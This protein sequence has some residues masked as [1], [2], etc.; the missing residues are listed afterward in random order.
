MGIG[1]PL[2]RRAVFFDRDG[3]LNKAVVRDGRPFPPASADEVEITAGAEDATRALKDAGFLLIVV[4]NQPDVARGTTS[5]ESVEAINARLAAVL[6]IDRFVMCYHQDS[7]NCD[8]RKPKPGMLLSSA[9]ELDID[10]ASSFLVGDRWRDIEAGKAA[11]CATIFIDY[12]YD[13]RRPERPGHKASSLAEAVDIILAEPR[14]Q[15]PLTP[16]K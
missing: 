8:C 3:V 6:P 5:R 14:N 9:R 13:E 7:D 1:R 11:G 10:L 12:S 2:S 15:Q 4:S 16:F